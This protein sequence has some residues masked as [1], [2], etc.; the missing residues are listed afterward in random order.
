MML[1]CDYTL[2]CYSKGCEWLIKASN[3]SKHGMFRIRAF[4]IEQMCPSKEK[5]I[6]KTHYYHFDCRDCES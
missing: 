2:D 4:N 3:I 6:H 1:S 5:F